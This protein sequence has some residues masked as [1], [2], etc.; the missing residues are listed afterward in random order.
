MILVSV[1]VEETPAALAA[2]RSWV[3]PEIVLERE[4]DGF[5][6]DDILD[7]LNG[8]GLLLYT[9]AGQSI[10]SSSLRWPSGLGVD[11]ILAR[12]D[13]IG[14]VELP[15][16]EISC[17]LGNGLG[18]EKG[19]DVAAENIDHGAEN[20]TILLPDVEG[21][22]GGDGSGVSSSGECGCTRGNETGEFTCGASIAD[23]GFVSDDDHFDETPFGPGDDFADLL[24]GTWDSSLVLA[25]EDTK[26][27]LNLRGD[28]SISDVLKGTA[29][30]AVNRRTVKPASLIMVTS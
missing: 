10:A 16:D 1:Q 28:A 2:E 17:L 4:H 19:V 14:N 23:D 30:G 13:L 20:I 5:A 7:V 21:L 6:S 18:V 12:A 8:I 11:G 3:L 25:D 15:L 27:H 26:N 9:R 22:G 24:L 29:I